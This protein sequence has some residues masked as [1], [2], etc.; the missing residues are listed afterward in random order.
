MCRWTRGP[1][2]GVAI[3]CVVFAA[4]GAAAQED[5]PVDPLEADEI[6][7]IVVTATR[8]ERPLLDVPGSVTVIDLDEIAEIGGAD[9]ADLIADV[10]GVDVIRYGGPG[11][12]AGAHLRGTYGVHTLVLVDGRTQNSPSLGGAD[13]SMLSPAFVE[14]VEIVRG[15]ASALYGTGAVGGVI[16]VFTREVPAEP[17]SEA[18]I[19]FG[20]FGTASASFLGGWSLGSGGAL[21]GLHAIRTDGHRPNSDFESNELF[22][23]LAFGKVEDGRAVVTLSLLDLRA[24][25]PGPKP[26]GGGEVTS[27]ED[28]GESTRGSLQVDYRLGGFRARASVSHWS[29]EA[30]TW[31]TVTSRETTKPEFDVSSSWEPRPWL[32]ALA[33]ADV[34]YDRFR[35]ESGSKYVSERTTGSPWGQI[36]FDRDAWQGIAGFRWDEPSDY[37]GKA[38]GRLSGCWKS[39]TGLRLEAGVGTAFRAPA[40]DDLYYP[41]DGY[42]EGNPNL[43]PETSVE[44]ELAVKWTPAGR[45]DVRLTG[46][47]FSKEVDDMI[48]WSPGPAGVW[49][50][51]NLNSADIRGVELAGSVPLGGGFAG[52]VGYIFMEAEEV[53]SRPTRGRLS[54]PLDLWSSRTYSDFVESAGDLSY[55]PDHQVTLGIGWSK[56]ALSGKVSTG[57]SARWV[58]E[59][60]RDYEKPLEL[61]EVDPVTGDFD[62]VDVRKTLRANWLVG[63]RMSW[64]WEKGE[65]FVKA[66]NLLDEEYARQFGYS[67][68]DRD[69]PMPGRRITVG[70]RTSF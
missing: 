59:V 53:R 38:S 19:S 20:S 35:V 54:D 13:I 23:K 17:V 42:S 62:V 61:S 24:G 56:Q 21:V 34:S 9:I 5:E 51:E 68:D 52:T 25:W 47:L 28:F 37:D 22:G 45:D 66:D 57:L 48:V 12:S 3:L 55:T 6:E 63:L 65:V 67:L 2:P 26:A 18:H 33:G 49:R 14:R 64:S 15:P 43:K 40:L 70:A 4:A 69:F 50:P 16:Q 7:E 30:D 8:T 46:S 32:K 60:S 1:W 41:F 39:G 11:S 36:E 31:G 27:L 29:D 10:E 44:G 58:S